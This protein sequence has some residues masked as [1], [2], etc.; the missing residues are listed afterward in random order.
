[1]KSKYSFSKILL[2]GFLIS[3]FSL[4]CTDLEEELFDQVT[5]ENFFQSE[6]EFISALGAA[7]T[8]LYSF[9][10]NGTILPLQEVTTDEMVVPTRGNDWD[11]GGNWRRLH[12]QTYTFEDDRVVGGWNFVFGGVNDCNRLIFQFEQ[13][14]TPEADVFIAELKV[15]RALFYYWA[16]DMYGNVPIVDRFDVEPGFL[17]PTRSRQEVYDFVE[18]SILQNI[19]SL[20]KETGLS[21]YGRINYYVA[22]TILAKLYLNAEVYTGTPQWEKANAS[23]D[24]VINSGNY[25]LPAE[26]FAN[27]VTNNQN[28]PEFIFAVPYDEVFAPGFNMG[29]MTLHYLS[30]NTYNL[31]AQPWNGFCSLQEFYES[32]EDEDVRKQSFLVGP[33]FDSNGDRLI[34]SGFE[35]PTPDDP[36]RPVDPD[37]APLTFTPEI[38]QLFPRA[39]RQAGARIGK[40]EYALGSTD[41]LNNDF[42]IYRYADVLLMKAEVLWRLDPASTE[43][44]GLVNMIR[45]RAGV[46]GFDAL[47]A[48]NI[49]AERGRELAFEVHRRTDLIRFGKYN[50]PWWAKPQTP[51]HVRIFPIPRTA[52]DANQNL[53]QNP[54]Y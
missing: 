28:S 45:E 35:A 42:A 48:D 15:V 29:M 11:D 12:L 52:L 22:H 24:E 46:D 8:R 1:M 50:D 49:L 7:Y 26:Y 21:T 23:L 14:G 25:S 18:N 17:P 36:G 37:G 19:N 2:T 16:L 3:V 9:G 51:P 13:L 10:G 44:L 40:W 20:S 54:G 47:T 32:F 27:F 39:L 30:Q 38:N 41:N 34:D 33:Q 5:Q 6:E 4:S 31:T 43:A 53:A